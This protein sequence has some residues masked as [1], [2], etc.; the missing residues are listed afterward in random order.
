MSVYFTSGKGW[1]I[2]FTLNGQRYTK[3]WFPTKRE[4]KREETQMRE[5]VTNPQREEETP[6][7]M[8]F[9]E[10]VNL[11]LDYVKAYNSE[12]HYMDHV[13]MAKRW[14]RRFKDLRCSELNRQL[15]QGFLLHRKRVS[16]ATA[17][18]ELR[19]LRALFNW[20]K[21]Q[22]YIE[23]N[24]TDGISFFPVERRRKF[25]PTQAE[26][27]SVIQAA[28]EDKKLLKRYPDAADYLRALRSTFARMSEINQLKWEDVDFENR[29]VT[30][31]TRKTRGGN[32][33][34]RQIPM[35]DELYDVLRR[36]EEN[37]HAELPY[38][39]WHKYY[40]R[41][42]GEKV[43]GPFQNRKQLMKR[44]CENAEVRYFRFH[45][46]RH[47]GA[48]ALEALGIPTVTVQKILGHENRSTTE[49]YLSSLQ[50]SEVAAMRKFESS[51]KKSHTDSHTEDQ[52]AEAS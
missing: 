34:P 24:P 18:K 28:E 29:S 14:I 40:S 20:G 25:V 11:R 2:D 51:R 5:E 1:R 30:L 43:A 50:G 26:I 42:A 39:F 41:K 46:L 9:L 36:R 45:A 15:I 37:R 33:T 48:S 47:A 6:I 19:Y 4:A 13:Y 22:G 3:S 44:L 35:T 27:D 7:D 21:K 49:I 23:T 12:R 38:V 52:L 31:Y 32:L 16:N 17:N 10:L 8:D